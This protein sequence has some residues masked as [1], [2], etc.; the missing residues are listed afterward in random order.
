MS[1]PFRF[2]PKGEMHWHQ[3]QFPRQLEEAN[4]RHFFELLLSDQA[5]G[6][7]A[8]EVEHHRG[9]LLF[10][11]GSTRPQVLENLLSRIPGLVVSTTERSLGEFELVVIMQANTSKRALRSDKPEAA[12]SAILGALATK[13]TARVVYQLLVGK[14]IGAFSVPS[15]VKELRSETWPGALLE[16]A[17]HGPRPMDSE[18]RKALADKRGQRSA[19]AA[20]RILT[21]QN[22]RAA[23][24][25]MHSALRSLESPGLRIHLARDRGDNAEQP[26]VGRKGVTLNL[27]ELV[28][29]CAWPHGERSYPGLDRSGAQALPGEKVRK[30]ARLVG[31]GTHPASEHPLGLEAE[32]GLRHLHVIGPTGVGK[33]TLLLRLILQ[34]ITAG[35]SVVVLDP[36]GDL[37]DDVLARVPDEHHQRVVLLDPSRRDLVVGFN[38]L[39]VSGHEAELAVDG[40]LH[41]FK[42]LFSSSW[43]PRTQDILHA[44]LLSLIG[45]DQATIAQVPRLLLDPA[46]RRHVRKQNKASHSSVRMFWEWFDTMGPEQRST[47]IAPLL[48]KLRSFTM[49]SGVRA[50]VG[51]VSPGFDTS[52]VFTD[53]RVLL[54]PLRSGLLGSE[55]AQL[56]GSMVVARLWQ[57]AQARSSLPGTKRTPAFVYLD[58]FQD[59]L[60]LPTD[61]SQ[62]MAQARGLGVGLVLAH[63]HLAQMDSTLRAAVLANAQSRIAF[64]LGHQDAKTLAAMSKLNAEDFE[65][66]SRYEIYAQ[67]LRNGEHTGFASARTVAPPRPLRDPRRLAAE[68]VKRDGQRPE[69][70]DTALEQAPQPEDEDGNQIGRRRLEP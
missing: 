38:P 47:V 36:K 59:Y 40:I 49:R 64:R 48:N 42:Q 35:R 41:I 11:I 7:I 62:V 9:E 65:N 45:T 25:R 3:L 22:N 34:D 21:S 18:R 46:F 17:L 14:R 52:T 66:L 23:I 15:Q 31:I 29:M 37:I 53:K 30:A 16:A 70:V 4:V 67:L 1:A 2:Q 69:E 12:T 68:L 5:L 50:M 39:D 19:R 56:L 44:S 60:R 20:V 28:A 6:D 24:A 57:L 54:V 43:G 58:E 8:L 26:S 33:S 27:D 32:D 13:T 51:Q 63:Q 55:T 10:R 61:M